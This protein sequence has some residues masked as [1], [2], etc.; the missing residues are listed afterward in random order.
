[1]K[2]SVGTPA[3]RHAGRNLFGLLAYLRAID[4]VGGAA[5]GE[6]VV[7]AMKATPSDDPVFGKVTIRADSVRDAGSA[8]VDQSSCQRLN[9]IRGCCGGSCSSR[10]RAC[11]SPYLLLLSKTVNA[12]AMIKTSIQ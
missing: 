9:L 6:A 10:R 1:M 3:Q 4:K 12:L 5:D 11:A 8:N 7:A 2:F